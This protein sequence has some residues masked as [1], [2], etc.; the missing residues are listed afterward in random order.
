MITLLFCS[1]PSPVGKAIRWF[2]QGTVGHV[3][4]MLPSG[5]LLGAQYASGMGAPSGVQIRP[6]RYGGMTN[7]T[8]VHLP[9]RLDDDEIY[10]FA[11][12]QIGKPY[13][14]TAIW[15]FVAGRDWRDPRGWYCSELI[16]AALED[17]QIIPRIETPISKITPQMLFFALS[18]LPGV[19][20][21]KAS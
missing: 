14:L 10:R 17:A 18:I 19:T 11:T 4:L 5:R 6:P 12:E 15:G 9:P 7:V 16:A 3:D 21:E 1:F 8:L 13:D 20:L 2:T